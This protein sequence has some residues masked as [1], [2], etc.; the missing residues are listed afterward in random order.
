MI[1]THPA[2][3]GIL[4]ELIIESDH[5]AGKKH[6]FEFVF[7]EIAAE[8]QTSILQGLQHPFGVIKSYGRR[9]IDILKKP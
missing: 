1:F 5:Y 4:G 2:H 9:L 7:V 3:W 8:P 6:T